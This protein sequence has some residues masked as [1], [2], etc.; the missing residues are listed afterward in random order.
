[1]TEIIDILTSIEYLLVAIFSLL[2]VWFT[3]WNFVWNLRK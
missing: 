3:V 1:M 2:A